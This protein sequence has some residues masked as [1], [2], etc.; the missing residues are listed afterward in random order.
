MKHIFLN[1]KGN[2][3]VMIYKESPLPVYSINLES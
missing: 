2:K 1:G 3:S